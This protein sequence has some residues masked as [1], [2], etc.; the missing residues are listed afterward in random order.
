M[1]KVMVVDDKEAFRRKIKRLPYWREHA[2]QFE[3]V[4]EAADGLKALELLKTESVDVV[5]TDIRMPFVNG[6]ELLKEIKQRDHRIAV[7]LLSEFAEFSYARE[8]MVNGAFDYIVKPV[9]ND[10]IEETFSRLYGFLQ[11][12]GE[13]V[14]N[15]DQAFRTLAEHLLKGDGEGARHCAK[16]ITAQI[17]QSKLSVEEATEKTVKQLVG[18]ASWLSKYLDSSKMPEGPTDFGTVIDQLTEEIF[19]KTGLGAGRMVREICQEILKAPEARYT[20]RS[21]S[22]RYFVNP[23]YLGSQ[24]KKETGISFSSYVTAVKMRRASCLLLSDELRIY[25]VADH[26]GYED[27]NYFS[28]LFKQSFGC[29]PKEYRDGNGKRTAKEKTATV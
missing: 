18:Q 12:V 11:T 16:E 27:V 26:L 9:D 20:I 4:R 23:K 6:L 3:I 28:R 25:E 13:R 14:Q 2:D 8:G 21:F 5:L 19:F 24:F 10:K 29:S 22:D 1:Y 15:D 17:A 7:V